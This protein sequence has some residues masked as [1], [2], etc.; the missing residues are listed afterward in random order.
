VPGAD[1]P[2][3]RASSG[4]AG[5]VRILVSISHRHQAQ[6]FL[7][8][9]DRGFLSTTLLTAPR[10]RAFHPLVRADNLN[11]LSLVGATQASPIGIKLRSEEVPELDIPIRSPWSLGLKDPERRG[12]PDRVGR[13]SPLPTI[14]LMLTGQHL[15]P[16]DNHP[17][18]KLFASISGL[19]PGSRVPS[20]R[21]FS[22][23]RPGHHDRF[24]RR[25]PLPARRYSLLCVRRRAEVSARCH[26]FRVA[27]RT[28]LMV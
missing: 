1:R 4:G 26:R 27:R 11:G 15:R 19:R 21:S 24:D 25:A 5:W 3:R 13:R 8:P 28:P 10:S 23:E 17:P 2:V 22:P 20:G 18:I 9:A 14:R 12:R 16:P 6:P 7:A